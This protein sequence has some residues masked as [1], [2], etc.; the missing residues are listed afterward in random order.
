MWF[1]ILLG[2]PPPP[3]PPLPRGGL[4]INEIMSDNR[5]SIADPANPE[6]P[7]FDDWVEV[8]NIGTQPVELGGVELRDRNGVFVFEP[9]A[10]DAGER[11]LVWT[12]GQPEQ[13]TLHAPFGV[14]KDGEPL[15]LADGSMVLDEVEVP[16]LGPDESWARLKDGGAEFGITDR[17][18]PG[19]PNGRQLPDDPCFVPDSGFDDHAYPC[20][21][22]RES[23]LA[24]SGGRAGVA[25]VKFDIFSFSDPARRRIAYVDSQ[26]YTLHDQFYI[27]TVVN[28]QVFEG[29]TEYPSFAGSFPTWKAVDDWAHSVD[30]ESIFPREQ[31]RFSGERLYSPYFYNSINGSPRE[32][33][34]GTVVF[35]EATETREELWAFELEAGDDIRPADLAVYFQM[36]E[37][38]GP[39]EFAEIVWLVRSGAQEAVAQ[40]VEAAG[41]PLASRIMRYTELSE[42]GEVEVYNPGITA[43][44]AFMVRTGEEGLED[45]RNEFILVVDE[46]PDYLPPCRALITAVPQTPLSHVSLLARS[47][48]IPNLYVAGITTDPAWDA[49]K[50]VRSPVA[51]EATEQGLRVVQLENSEFAQWTALLETTPPEL[52]SVDPAGL[53]WTVDLA[54]AEPMLE[55]RPIVG[56]KAA[57]MRQLLATPGIDTPDTPLALTTRAYHAHMDGLPSPAGSPDP[58]WVARM[59]DA[60]PFLSTLDAP[61]RFAVLE[62]RAAYD[63]RYPAALDADRIDNFLSLLPPGNPTGDLARGDGLRGHVAR[64]PLDPGVSDTLLADLQQQFAALP[65]GQGLRFRSSST[66]EDLEGFNGAGLYISVTGFLDPAD[67][68]P[69]DEAIRQVWAAYWG[70][71]AFEE[72]RRAGINPLDGGMAILVHPRFDDGF[73]RANA[74]ITLTRLP[75]GSSQM[76]VNAQI[77]SISVAN[78]PTTCPPVLPEQILV[79]EAGIERLSPSSETADPVLSDPELL[80]LYDQTRAAVDGWLFEENSAVAPE[81]QRAVL[82]LDLE[83]RAMLSGWAGSTTDRLVIK[84]AR[85]LDPSPA[86]L[87]VSVRDLAAPEDLLGRASRI[88]RTE[89]TSDALRVVADSLNTDPLQ[90]PEMGYADTPFIIAVEVA[91]LAELPGVWAAGEGALWSHLDLASG[92]ITTDGIDIEVADGWLQA[93]DSGWA[94]D[95]DGQVASGGPMSCTTT[96]LWASPDDFLLQILDQ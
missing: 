37:S 81:R 51:I 21:S 29:L 8:L 65:A 18:T 39:P 23:F 54:A 66:V 83:A 56:G 45:S 72:R 87:P 5:T 2:C 68:R 6:C 20:I 58:G 60:P 71:E 24:L 84:Q 27:F 74:V 52:V 92:Q 32:V 17:P 50:R 79:T 42:P 75:D 55:L 49:W 91:A 43:G 10:L 64:S 59:L 85:S 31:I 88:R 13:G 15:W 41:G 62:G 67:G 94:L 78:P 96:T 9:G 28:G 22:E 40:Q 86:G 89:C 35:R 3:T 69:A 12:D 30:L 82:T 46:I 80:D 38:S 77:G 90:P 33:G 93:G 44:R 26:F 19:E 34:V 16:A 14:S 7:E 4:V 73:E 36:L 11:V 61:L 47:R 63:A 70:A 25:V 76:Q 53:P 95:L 57:G 1:F 48:G